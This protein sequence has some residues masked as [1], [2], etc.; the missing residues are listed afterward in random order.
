MSINSVLLGAWRKRGG[1]RCARTFCQSEAARRDPA[2]HAAH[3]GKLVLPLAGDVK[4]QVANQQWLDGI[5]KRRFTAV[6]KEASS[7][8]KCTMTRMRL[9]L[10]QV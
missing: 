5:R 10:D 2:E 9:S 6:R 1:T 3:L 8:M 4:H 7:S